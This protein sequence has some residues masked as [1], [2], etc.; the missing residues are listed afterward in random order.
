MTL[1]VCNVI[2]AQVQLGYDSHSHAALHNETSANNHASN[3]CQQGLGEVYVGLAQ[4]NTEDDVLDGD[5]RCTGDV[6]EVKAH[7][8]TRCS[9]GP[10]I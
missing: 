6:V 8:T 10:V 2:G 9:L 1:V 4:T 7:T 3:Y 5:V